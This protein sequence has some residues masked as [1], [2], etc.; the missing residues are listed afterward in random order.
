MM[1]IEKLL[2]GEIKENAINA[3]AVLSFFIMV[4]ISLFN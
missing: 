3:A 1:E 2:S 4:F